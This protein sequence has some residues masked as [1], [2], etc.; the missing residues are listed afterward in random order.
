MGHLVRAGT[1]A[2]ALGALGLAILIP[3]YLAMEQARDRAQ[4]PSYP[5]RLSSLAGTWLAAFV[6]VFFASVAYLC[7][8]FLFLDKRK[9]SSHW[10][11]RFFKGLGV[12]ST[13]VIIAALFSQVAL[14]SLNLIRMRHLPSYVRNAVVPWHPSEWEAV[15]DSP[16]CL[17]VALLL[18][19][20]SF[21]WQYRKD[22]QAVQ[23]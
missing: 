22:G 17:L 8:R 11:D 14:L 12:A 7:V 13:T 21:Y 20:C 19:V 6:S 15:R 23:G 3:I 2:I 5:L 18:F 4:Y 16:A 9:G 1:A 10:P